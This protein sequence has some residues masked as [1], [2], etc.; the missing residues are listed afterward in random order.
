MEIRFGLGFVFVVVS[1]FI[2]GNYQIKEFNKLPSLKNTY[3]I[4]AI[5]SN[6]SLDRFY[7]EKNEQEIINE[8]IAL[9]EPEKNKPTFELYIIGMYAQ[10]TNTNAHAA[11]THVHIDAVHR[12]SHFARNTRLTPHAKMQSR[13]YT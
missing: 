13:M 12:T 5:S 11:S 4:K 9:S 1:F 3:S 10:D 2:Y 7:I 6:I 8:L